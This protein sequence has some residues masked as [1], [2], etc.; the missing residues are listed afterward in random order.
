MKHMIDFLTHLLPQMDDGSKSV[1]ESHEMLAALAAQ[2]VDTVVAS[3]NFYAN[4]E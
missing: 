1:E 2:G 4:D 3:P